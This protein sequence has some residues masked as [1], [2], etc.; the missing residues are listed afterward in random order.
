MHQ[1]THNTLIMALIN[2][3]YLRTGY[4]IICMWTTL[5]KVPGFSRT[6][7][8]LG[9]GTL[10]CVKHIETTRT[11]APKSNRMLCTKDPPVDPSDGSEMTLFGLW[12]GWTHGGGGSVCSTIHLALSGS[13]V[14][15]T[16]KKPETKT[17]LWKMFHALLQLT[18]IWVQ[19]TSLTNCC[20]I[21]PLN[22]RH[23]VGTVH[24]F[25]FWT[26]APQMFSFFKG[27]SPK[28]EFRTPPPQVFFSYLCVETPTQYLIFILFILN[29]EAVLEKKKFKG[30]NKWQNIVFTCIYSVKF[31]AIKYLCPKNSVALKVWVEG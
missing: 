6:W 19:L 22:I 29:A 21:I 26:L 18:D 11:V 4:N 8:R 15:W 5:I 23:F 27:R 10:W 25:S 13:T 3:A 20:N 7:H 31:H 28:Q 24:S 12:S 1:L 9:T 17:G 14:W 2:P 30:L 16:V